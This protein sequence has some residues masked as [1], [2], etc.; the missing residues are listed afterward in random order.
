VC[1]CAGEPAT[2]FELS[3]S[4]DQIK[5]RKLEGGLKDAEHWGVYGPQ[6]LGLTDLPPQLR[7][8]QPTG[9]VGEQSDE[10]RRRA[11][12]AATVAR[13]EGEDW[14]SIAQHLRESPG[15]VLKL[16]PEE[17]LRVNELDAVRASSNTSMSSS[18]QPLDSELLSGIAF[19]VYSS[20]NRARVFR[21]F[22]M[23][24]VRKRDH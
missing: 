1:P 23:F 6:K 7:Q 9:L 21:K 14:G 12:E 16:R 2:S 18:P 19:T 24:T 5:L 15:E 8:M 20:E 3:L 10:G 11:L 22:P 17:R 4:P 13:A